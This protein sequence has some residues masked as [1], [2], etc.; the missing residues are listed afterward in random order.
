MKSPLVLKVWP[1]LSSV[2]PAAPSRFG[3]SRLI[4]EVSLRGVS[5]RPHEF[6]SCPEVRLA[7]EGA[8]VETSLVALEQRSRHS[9]LKDVA[10]GCCSWAAQMWGERRVSSPRASQGNT[11]NAGLG[12]RA[13]GGVGV[14]RAKAL[15]LGAGGELQHR[16]ISCAWLDAD[17]SPRKRNGGCCARC[18]QWNLWI[19]RW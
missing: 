2:R 16:L 1:G 11:P 9:R 15:V 8:S 18:A 12:R 3:G 6:G 10:D 19:G 17:H 4:V 5:A 13:C 7:R 14:G